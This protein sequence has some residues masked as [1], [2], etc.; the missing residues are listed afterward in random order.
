MGRA[1][2]AAAAHLDR[3]DGDQAFHRA[4]IVTTRFY[5][6]HLL[7][8]AAACAASVQAGDAAIAGMGDEIF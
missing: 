8:Q 3:G 6:D 2:L 5:A 7:P 4:K 1:A